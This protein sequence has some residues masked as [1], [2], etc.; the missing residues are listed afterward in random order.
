[1]DV[2]LA[3]VAVVV[4]LTV[5]DEEVGLAAEE[6]AEVAGLLA[7]E[8]EV[9]GL[10]VAAL[11]EEGWFVFTRPALVLVLVA[12]L[13]TVDVDVRDVFTEEPEAVEGREVVVEGRDVL[14]VEGREVVVAEGRA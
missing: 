4:L 2:E 8:L 6:V 10:L 11:L 13:A 14:V 12:G 9:V 7:D 5:E 3:G 1:V